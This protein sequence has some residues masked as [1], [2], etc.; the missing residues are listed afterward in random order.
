MN[1]L[2]KEGRRNMLLVSASILLVS[3]HTIY[4]YHSVRPEIEEK[5]LLQQGV[6]FLLT[7]GLLIMI[8]QGKKWAIIVATVLFS[9]A[10]A[11]AVFGMFFVEG[12]WV[13]KIPLAVMVFVYS[14]ALLVFNRSNGFKA[15]LV[16]QR[17]K[18]TDSKLN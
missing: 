1:L 17:T 10:I 3:I 8:Y 7:I 12:P 14:W 18:A 11:T 5:K 13:G 9:L 4:F 16:Y 6:R 15:F 2:V